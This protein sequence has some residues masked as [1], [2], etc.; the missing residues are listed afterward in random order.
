MQHAKQ[1][2]LKMTEFGI[3]VVSTYNAFDYSNVKTVTITGFMVQTLE[4]ANV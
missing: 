1:Q 2:K 3:R 4:F